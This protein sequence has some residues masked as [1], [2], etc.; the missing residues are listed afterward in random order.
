MRKDSRRVEGHR[1]LERRSPVTFLLDGEQVT[2]FQGE[3]IAAALMGAGRRAFRTTTRNGA[4][5]GLHCGIG[6]CFDC[7]VTVE[8]QPN[9][10]ACMIQVVEGMQVKT[11][12]GLGSVESPDT[13][14]GQ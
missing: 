7:L 5:R 9:S 13:S 8:G 14:D 1:G 12:A 3:T 11:Q 10:R 2:A 6:F 4:P